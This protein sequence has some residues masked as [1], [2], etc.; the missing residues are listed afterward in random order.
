MRKASAKGGKT[1]GGQT[2]AG[3][4]RGGR[5]K[6]GSVS[7]DGRKLTFR[8]QNNADPGPKNT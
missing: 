8:K 2:F 5:E 3:A 6:K 7:V 4:G 1:R